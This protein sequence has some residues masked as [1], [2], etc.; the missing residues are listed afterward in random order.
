MLFGRK[1]SNPQDFWQWFSD[2]SQKIL[3]LDFNN[4]ESLQILNQMAA[5]LSKY[6]QEISFEITLND[7]NS[8][9][10]VISA[11][12]VKSNKDDVKA[13]VEAA[14][15]LPRWTIQAFRQRKNSQY[16]ESE[17][18]KLGVKDTFFVAEK[19]DD[20]DKLDIDLF[21]KDWSGS[22]VQVTLSFLQLDDILGEYD[23]MS[24]IGEIDWHN[25][26]DKP[27]KAKPIDELAKI[28]D[29]IK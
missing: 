13:L 21:I 25:L 26:N 15:S 9:T 24:Y 5:Q 20:E 6:N 8:R 19:N 16:V 27:A 17:G 28:V 22:E 4:Q 11:E 2:N 12:G 14:P 10:L 18:H 7:D 1:K 3:D 23:V 29:E